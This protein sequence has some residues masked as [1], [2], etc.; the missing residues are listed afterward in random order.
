M[1]YNI[2]RI[3]PLDLQPR[4]AIGVKIPFSAKAVF[5]STYTTKDAIK[6]NLINLL[7]TDRDERVFNPNFGSRLRR[8]LFSNITNQ[9]IDN[10]KQEIQDLLEVYFPTLNI[11]ELQIESTPDTNQILMFLKY[12]LTNTNIEDEIVINV[13]A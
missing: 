9:T 3:N 4:K 13:E 1:A 5:E 11:D 2:Q 10:L 8:T 7:L 6:N 12:N